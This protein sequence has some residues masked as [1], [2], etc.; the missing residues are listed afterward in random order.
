VTDAVAA[1]VGQAGDAGADAEGTA[2]AFRDDPVGTV[3]G[4]P[5]ARSLRGFPRRRGLHLGGAEGPRCG[6][7]GEV[8]CPAHADLDAI[9]RN[10]YTPTP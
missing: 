5:V 6:W 3:G 7:C 9:L 4:W 2:E 8:C 10:L 1:L